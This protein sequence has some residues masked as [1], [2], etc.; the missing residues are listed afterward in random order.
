MTSDSR[1]VSFSSEQWELET[2]FRITGHEFHIIDMLIVTIS[3]NGVAGRGEA[4]GVYYLNETGDSI[5]TQAQSVRDEVAR[6]ADREV[7]RSLLPAGGARNA[8]DCALWDL[9]AK[10]SNRS[11]WDLTGI[12]PHRTPSFFTVGLDTPEN[13]ALKARSLDS[14]RIKVKLDPE[15]PLERISAVRE[16]RPKAMIIVDVN[17]GWHFE[18]LVELAPRFKDLNISMIEQPLPR[19]AD[20]ELESYVS[21]VPLCADESC[22]TTD[23]FEQAARRYQVIN[24]TLDKTGGL[25]EALDLARMA[26]RRGVDLMVGNMVGTSLGMAPGFVIAQLCK[27]VDLDGTLY[28]KGDREHPMT[29]DHGLLSPPASAL[30]G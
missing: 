30:W 12:A 22:L 17:Q 27:F 1:E 28:L 2:P 9:E 26:H 7:L 6:G 3:E 23:E 20:E 24:I 14:G 29:F 25:T 19:S 11:I 8:I 5:L 4:A 18:Q 16:A 13:M 10:L 21:P 15:Q